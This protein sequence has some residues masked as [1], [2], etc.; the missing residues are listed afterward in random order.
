[1]R[2]L[3]LK[4]ADAFHDSGHEVDT[5]LSEGLVGAPDTEIL[6]HARLEHRILLTMDKGIADIRLFPPYVY[7]GI[8]LFRPA[9]SGRAEVLRF[10]RQALPDLL[11]TNWRGVWQSCRH[12]ASG[13]D[14]AFC[15]TAPRYSSMYRIVVS[16]ICDVF[17]QPFSWR[18]TISPCSFWARKKWCWKR[19]GRYLSSVLAEK[20]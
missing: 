4:I 9:T 3:P 15:T 16:S 12:G 1:M 13:F 2:N 8:V 17:R 18:T 19:S 5:V 6:D 11:L 14:R 7:P 10:V 20:R